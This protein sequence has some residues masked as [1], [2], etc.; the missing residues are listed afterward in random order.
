MSRRGEREI[1]NRGADQRNPGTGRE[2]GL[3]GGTEV[4]VAP[5][6]TDL[7]REVQG[8]G[9]TRRRSPGDMKIVTEEWECTKESRLIMMTYYSLIFF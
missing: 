9:P 2:K 5:G 1:E 3:E 7:D 4:G 8:I 6:G